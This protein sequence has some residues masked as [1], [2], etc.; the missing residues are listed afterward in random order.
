MDSETESKKSQCLGMT[1][2]Y[3]PRFAR[4]RTDFLTQ[5]G[6]ACSVRFAHLA[7]DSLARLRCAPP[8]V[9]VK[10]SRAG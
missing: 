8:I 9:V 7:A 5:L 1:H 4:L 10:R 2:T 6:L 3:L